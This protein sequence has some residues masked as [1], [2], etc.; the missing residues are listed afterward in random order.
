MNTY[1]DFLPPVSPRF[2]GALLASVLVAYVVVRV[3]VGPANSLARRWGLIA[4]RASLLLVLLLLLA[5]PVRVIEIPSSTRPAEVF[6]LLDASQSMA[7]VD[8]PS[9]RWDQAIDLIRRSSQAVFDRALAQVSL[10]RFG[11]RLQAIG[12]PEK[13]GV[14]RDAG[15]V[16]STSGS[17]AFVPEPTSTRDDEATRAGDFEPN[18]P[19]TQLLVALRQ[20]SSRFGREPPAA[21]VLFSDGRAR[22][23]GRVQEVATH[24]AKLGVPI[25]VV[26]VGDQAKGGDVSIVSLVAPGRVRKQTEVSVHAFLRSYGYDGKRAEVQLSAVNDAG[27]F[28]K[29]L[30]SIPVTLQS[31]F[32]SAT[33]SF[34]S[35]LDTRR[36]EVSIPPQ[37]DEISTDNNKFGSNVSIDRTK[38]RV[39]YLEGSPTRLTTIVRE[40]R[41]ELQGPHSYLQNALEDDADIEC[42]VLS[43]AGRQMQ[44]FSAAIGSFPRNIAELTAF[45][46]IVLSNVPHAAFTDQQIEW[47]D[48]WISRRG[49]GLCMV[50]GRYSFGSGGW[51]GSTLENML[52]VQIRGHGDWSPSVEV[53]AHTTD[54]STPHPLFQILE[55]ETN[56]RKVLASFPGFQG[57]HLNLRPK[58]NL[59]TV[60][61]VGTLRGQA[62]SGSLFSAQG[63]RDLL[64]AGQEPEVD[65]KDEFPLLAVGQYGKGRTMIMTTPITGDGAAQFVQWGTTGNEYYAKFWRNAIYWLTE[66]S[67]VG[68][69]RLVGAADKRYYRPGETINLTASAYDENANYTTDYRLV[70]MIEPQTFDDIESDYSVMRWPNNIKRTS[71]EEGPFVA[72]GEEFEVPVNRAT[73]GRDAYS[74]E[75]AI[76]DA[77]SMGTAN[78]SMRIELTAYEDVTQID[79]T[80]VA[81]QVLHDP[82]EQQNPFPNH[83]LLGEL[84]QKSGGQILRDAESIVNMLSSLPARHGPAEIHKTPLWSTWWLLAALLG[85]L[86]AEWCWRRW[87]G[88]A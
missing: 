30:D 78:Q 2:I 59:T 7:M 31:G 62:P 34:R 12:T 20:I 48:W 13:L 28:L 68:R 44:S 8:G 72:W 50:G 6:Y 39:L 24:F 82:I 23:E 26:P 85:V 10:F 33:L 71:G 18:E 21:I 14:G 11:R 64:R 75:L 5:N 52:P 43:V 69:R 66:N 4:L 35:D 74:L 58:P 22:D 37:T 73:D 29:K 83:E 27:Q 41:R 88:L 70:A 40:G 45:D 63:I 9:T 81:I 55:D 76:A 16:S 1:F 42:L 38:I 61:A 67:F 15:S 84:A 56:N 77:L 80:S 3:T 17:V 60:L 53:S 87:V 25:H 47:L 57:A 65:A 36:I 54:S 51:G 86:S 46:A 49:G 79:S 19:D 32:Q